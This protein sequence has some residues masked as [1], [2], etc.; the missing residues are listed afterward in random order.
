MTIF[1]S[2]EEETAICLTTLASLKDELSPEFEEGA[3][4]QPKK[5]RK[6]VKKNNLIISAVLL[7]Y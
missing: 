1:A 4:E 2:L 6:R 7:F 5:E 3:S